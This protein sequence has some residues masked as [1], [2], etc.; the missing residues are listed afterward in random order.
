MSTLTHPLQHI[1]GKDHDRHLRRSGRH[2]QHWTFGGRT[3]TNLCFPDDIN[4]LAGEEEELA[5]LVEQLDKA[6]TAYCMEIS[7]EKTKLMTNNASGTNTEIKVNGQ[8]LETVTSYKYLGSVITD[9]GSKHEILSRIAQTKAAL[10]RLKAVWNDR[11]ISL[12]SKILPMCF[13]V[14]AI[15][16]HACESWTPHSRAP[17]KNTSYGN[18]VLPQDTMHLIQRPCYQWGSLCQDPAGSQPTQRPPDHCEEMQT[19]V[20]WS[21]S[22]LSGLAKTILQGIVKEGRRYW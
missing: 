13:L 19:A 3:I 12:S 9:E 7:V 8:K 14:T 6:S 1:S 11:S 2:C 16:L 17:K 18:E 4:G 10:T 15:F 5:K 21:F 20:V 22:H